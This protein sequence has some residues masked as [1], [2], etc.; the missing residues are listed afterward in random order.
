MRCGICAV[1]LG[2]LCLIAS[3][4]C[5]A[6]AGCKSVETP[7]APT[8]PVFYPFPPDPPRVQYLTAINTARDVIPKQ[9]LGFPI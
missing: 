1:A 8:Q 4:L 7:P 9:R 3:L 2:A 5:A 6:L